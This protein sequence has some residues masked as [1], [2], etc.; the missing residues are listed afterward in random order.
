MQCCCCLFTSFIRFFILHFVVACLLPLLCIMMLLLY[1]Y[2]FVDHVS[3][4]IIFLL[5]AFIYHFE[6]TIS[7]FVTVC[8]SYVSRHCPIRLTTINHHHWLLCCKWS[9]EYN[10]HLSVLTGLKIEFA[11]IM[12]HAPCLPC[13]NYWPHSAA[14]VSKS[15]DFLL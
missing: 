13:A 5:E 14:N 15:H 11:E 7:I 6:N 12:V 2:F 4:A 3:K 9:I 1:F 10:H 8:T